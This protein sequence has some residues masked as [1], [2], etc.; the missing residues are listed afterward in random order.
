M[1]IGGAPIGGAPIAAI[2]QT[3]PTVTVSV[4]GLSIGRATVT[5]PGTARA[6][7]A[8]ASIGTATATAS[9]ALAA[10]G[11]GQANGVAT[12][13]AAGSMAAA[14][15]GASIGTAA[16]TAPGATRTAQ[17][18]SSIGYATAITPKFAY[19]ATPGGLFERA[20]AG[21]TFGRLDSVARTF[22]RKTVGRSFGRM[23]TDTTRIFQRAYVA[24]LYTRPANTVAR[25]FSRALVSRV[26][27]GFLNGLRNV[28]TSIDFDTQVKDSS[29]V[30]SYLFDFTNFPECEAGET[31]STPVV[32]A[33][34]GLTIGT[35]TIT[36]FDRDDVTAGKGLQV[37]ISGGT[38]GEQYELEARA[39]FSGGATRVVK[40]L[41]YVE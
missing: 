37:T 35:P 40:G 41:L 1:S 25:T 30:I 4:V 9:A 33:V 18:G 6:A 16:P 23:A 12:G 14:A 28:A 26:F 15:S 31:L 10:S 39:T 38:A 7:Q 8:G 13:A 3:N 27:R 34:A 36:T 11:S 22:E 24:R 5:A 20:I 32:D 29:E 21:R 17:A 19:A 2:A